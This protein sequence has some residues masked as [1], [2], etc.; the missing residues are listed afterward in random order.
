MALLKLPI[1]EGN[2]PGNLLEHVFAYNRNAEVL[3][4]YDFIDVI[5]K[6]RGIGWQIK[7]TMAST[8]VTWIRLFVHQ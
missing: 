2:I 8:P 7:S 5:D 6:E 4:T 1:I 3:N